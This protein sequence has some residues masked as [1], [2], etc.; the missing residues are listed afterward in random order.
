[1]RLRTRR[2]LVD[3]RWLIEACGNQVLLDICVR[4]SDAAQLYRAWSSSVG[5]DPHRDLAA[6][7]LALMEAALDHDDDRAV[8]LFEA[9][10]ERTAVILLQFE[11]PEIEHSAL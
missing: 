11:A 4:L 8:H 5:G 7:H 9:H 2:G 1:M 6:E 3:N 10:I